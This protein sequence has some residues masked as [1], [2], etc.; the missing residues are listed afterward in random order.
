MA[1]K[2]TVNKKTVKRQVDQRHGLTLPPEA[3]VALNIFPKDQLHLRDAYIYVIRMK[4][5]TLESVGQA[6]GLTRER[7][8]QLESR[9]KPIDAITILSNPGSYPVPEVPK[10][11]IEEEI[12]VYSEPSPEILARL[13]E[14]RPIAETVRSNSPRGR[15]AAEEYTMLLNYAHVVEGVPIYRIAKRLGVTHGA[16]RFRLVRY[17][18]LSTNGKS[19]AYKK[20]I[21]KNRF[22]V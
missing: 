6:L 8:R 10:R 16:I 13:I 14:L 5:W 22:P 3:V 11:I 9:A 12:T 4:G 15:E 2:R 21:D 19:R 18:Y 20:I 1:Y 17:G 7:I